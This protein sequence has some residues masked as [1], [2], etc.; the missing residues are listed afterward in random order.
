MLHDLLDVIRHPFA[1]WGMID[2]RRR[3]WLGLA[4]LGLSVS[5]P[6]LL[7]EI[8]AFGPF[9]PPAALGS[10]PS[11][12]AAGADLYARWTYAHRFELPLYG[13]VF[14]VVLWL[15][16]VGVIHLIARSLQGR[17]DFQGYLKLAGYVAFAG[18]ISLPV[19]ALGSIAKL[20]G[21]AGL[22]SATGQLAGVVGVAVFLWQ[23][24]LLIASAREHYRI[25]TERAVAA[26]I[27]PL[28]AVAVLG[29]A[30]VIVAAVML[31]L[32]Q[33]PMPA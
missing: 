31:V 3:L 9:R 4:A 25:S 21:N 29:V 24:L 16:A 32:S 1:A 2:R 20:G 26:V 17:G 12:T 15:V 27:G 14:S 33:Q 7:A 30:L 13:I 10:L 8:A 19:T 11:M 28:G 18:L 6:A 22:Q 5:L 23:N